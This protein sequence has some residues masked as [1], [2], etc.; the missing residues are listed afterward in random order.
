MKTS[1]NRET[2]WNIEASSSRD[3]TDVN[4]Q[5]RSPTSSFNAASSNRTIPRFEPLT[6]PVPPKLISDSTNISAT[7]LPAVLTVSDLSSLASNASAS[8]SATEFTALE[9]PR[10]F[11]EHK[12]RFSNGFQV[13]SFVRVGCTNN[14]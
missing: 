6:I 14:F 12:I 8:A 5:P 13:K 9:V 4:S 3:T 1:E 7:Q 11:I 10:H 2:G